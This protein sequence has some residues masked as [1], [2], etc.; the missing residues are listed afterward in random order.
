MLAKILVIEDDLDAAGLARSHLQKA[1]YATDPDYAVKIK[2]ILSNDV[3]K[4]A[5]KAFEI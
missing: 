1:G 3:F 4:D 5:V 2:H